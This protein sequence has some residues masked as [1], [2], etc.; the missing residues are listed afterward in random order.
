[1]GVPKKKTTKTRRNTRR[2]HLSL[3]PANLVLCPQC[4]TPILPH[5]V[6]QNCGYYKGK[7]RIK[8]ELKTKTSKSPK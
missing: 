2:S 6:C 3:K 4:Q 8:I 1:M 7:E 5:R